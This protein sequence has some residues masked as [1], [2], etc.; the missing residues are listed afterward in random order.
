MLT[1]EQAQAA[2]DALLEDKRAEQAALHARLQERRLASQKWMGASTLLGLA[3][4]GLIGHYAVGQIFPWNLLG[5]VVGIAIGFALR[6][7]AA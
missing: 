3:V 7:R 6:R 4:G 5:M 1:K 2:A